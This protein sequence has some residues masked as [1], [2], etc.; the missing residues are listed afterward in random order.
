MQDEN[1][2]IVVYETR[3]QN[4]LKPKK[5][6]TYCQI[7]QI[8]NTHHVGEHSVLCTSTLM[9]L[10]CNNTAGAMLWGIKHCKSFHSAE[11]VTSPPPSCSCLSLWMLEGCT[12]WF[13]VQQKELSFYCNSY[14]VFSA[15]LLKIHPLCLC[16]IAY[17]ADICF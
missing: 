4:I 15:R 6:P 17:I 16:Y 8:E 9:S 5:T 1:W 3:P 12:I 11:S 14:F 2:N 13:K 10:V 7:L